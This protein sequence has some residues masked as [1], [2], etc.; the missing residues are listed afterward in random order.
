MALE[1]ESDIIASQ[2]EKNEDKES[3]RWLLIDGSPPTTPDKDW[4]YL[5]FWYVSKR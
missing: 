2:I 4:D 5:L 3:D 1:E